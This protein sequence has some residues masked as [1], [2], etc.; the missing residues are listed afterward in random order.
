MI[1]KMIQ[2]MVQ[3]TIRYAP[4]LEGASDMEEDAKEG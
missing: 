3:R 1:Q 2:R 4:L